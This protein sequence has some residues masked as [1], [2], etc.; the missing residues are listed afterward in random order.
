VNRRL[1]ILAASAAVAVIG[2][3][4]IAMAMSNAN[5]YTPR[6]EAY[7]L[8]ADGIHVTVAYCGSTGDTFASQTLREDER[9]VVVGVRLR[10]YQGFQNGTVLRVGYTLR[11]TLSSRVVQGENGTVVPAGAQFLCPG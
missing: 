4:V 9:S 3:V 1:V 6:P 8:S 2:A 11:S 10:Q 7:E 5:T